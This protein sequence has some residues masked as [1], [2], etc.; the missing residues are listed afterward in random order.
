MALLSAIGVKMIRDPFRPPI[1]DAPAADPSRGWTLV[2]L[3][4]ATSIDALAVGIGIGVLGK[5]DPVSSV[6]I[7]VVC[8]FFR[9]PGSRS[10][11]AGDLL[12]R[13]VMRVGGVS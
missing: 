1:S 9:S 6:V 11:E 12:G 10:E 5:A 4:V 2:L 3:S 13:R 8:A 7:G